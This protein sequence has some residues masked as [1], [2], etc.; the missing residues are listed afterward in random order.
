MTI[1]GKG[2]S[3]TGTNGRFTPEP[4]LG[5][6]GKYSILYLHCCETGR[7]TKARLFPIVTVLVPVPVPV[8]CSVNKS[9]EF[10]LIEFYRIYRI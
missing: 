6:N 1:Y 2:L 7:G 8:R 5:P 4:V 10:F 9:F 3:F